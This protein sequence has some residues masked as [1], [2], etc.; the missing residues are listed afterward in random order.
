MI[1]LLQIEDVDSQT[2]GLALLRRVYPHTSNVFASRLSDPAC[3]SSLMLILQTSGGS[4]WA[5]D[6]PADQDAI[7]GFA[8]LCS[9]CV[10]FLRLVTRE[11]GDVRM[12]VTFQDGVEALLAIV[13]QALGA[14]ACAACDAFFRIA[15]D[16][17]ACVRQLADHDAV[18]RKYMR[19][20]GHLAGVM[21]T[22]RCAVGSLE[23]A[24]AARARL[25][26]LAVS[27]L[28]IIAVFVGQAPAGR[29]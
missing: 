19:E 3:I 13:A 4:P 8:A 20:A 24:P 6:C 22:L 16:A 27:L 17:C 21:R 11:H 23:A 26:E 7:Q 14:P 12:I 10:H 2:Q 18:A 28:D 15:A 25:E 5:L 29:C 1:K 9:E